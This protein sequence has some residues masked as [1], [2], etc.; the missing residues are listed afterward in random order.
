MELPRP[1]GPV[2]ELLCRWL[3]SSSL[4][5]A[6]MQAALTGALRDCAVVDDDDLQVALWVLYELHYQGFEGVD[7]G[8]EWR[9]ETLA[10]RARIEEVFESELRRAT[11]DAVRAVLSAPG[12]LADR[13]FA[14]VGN[15]DSS[16]LA[17]HLQ[18]RAGPDQLCEFLVHRSV[19]QL[20]E[21]DPH[22]WVIPRL[23]GRAKV[24][25]AEIQY[26]E[27]GSGRATQLH[28]QLFA[29][30]MKVCGLVA[31]YGAYVD[32]VPGLT[33]AS[34]NAMSLFGLHRRLRGAAIGHLAALEASSSL[35]NRRY[36]A[37]VRR[38]GYG[39]QAARYFDEHVA[40]DAVHEQIAV[41]EVCCVAAAAEPALVP[42]IAFGAAACLH[43]DAAVAGALLTAWSE[44][45]SSL[46]APARS[47][48]RAGA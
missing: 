11:Y 30:T 42:D 14:L 16:P 36:A 6:P 26:D 23:T 24:A 40:A 18:R 27:Y 43:L 41:R 20:K 46:L 15:A 44:G 5:S 45:R 33:L 47:A 2:S 28:S 22:T 8:W 17:R 10:V 35:P 48:S 4:D 9:P 32:M 12:S 19:Y 13:L 1:R 25:L 34:S 38:L 39:E 31:D 7:P 37:A 21:A 29:D 3:T